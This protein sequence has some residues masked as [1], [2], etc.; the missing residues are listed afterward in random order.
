VVATRLVPRDDCVSHWPSRVWPYSLPRQP[1]FLGLPGKAESRNRRA[2]RRSGLE[3]VA[4]AIEKGGPAAIR[5]FYEQT[6]V[7]SLAIYIDPSM[8]ASGR[9]KAVGLPTTLLIDREGRERW[10]KLG[11]AEGDSAAVMEALRGS[12]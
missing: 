3:V 6:G 12:L 1:V 11:P 9:L 2:R 5:Q 4:L 10:R 7:R 8:E